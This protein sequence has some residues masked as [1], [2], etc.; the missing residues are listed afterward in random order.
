MTSCVAAGRVG[1]GVGDVGPVQ[2]MQDPVLPQHRLVPALGHHPGRPAQH[3]AEVAPGDLED[4]VRCPAADEAGGHRLPPPGQV[5][6]VHPRPEAL[7]VDQACGP[8]G[9]VGFLF[10]GVRCLAIGRLL[11]RRR[12]R[13]AARVGGT[14]ARAASLTNIMY[15]AYIMNHTPAR[16]PA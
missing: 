9:D 15:V 1:L 10:F 6:G 14:G 11:C 7:L 4:L 5:L 3:G 8:G 2:G 16:P 12:W 13:R